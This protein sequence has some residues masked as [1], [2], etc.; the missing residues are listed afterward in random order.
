MQNRLENKS[1]HLLPLG[2]A[3]SNGDKS[4]KPFLKWAGGKRWLIPRIKY[5]LPKSFNRYFEPF[6][7]AGALFFHLRPTNGV[8][9][10][11]NKELINSYIQIR[12]NLPELL[13]QLKKLHYSKRI[14]NKLRFSELNSEIRRAVRF[15]Y[16]NKTCWNGLYRENKEGKFNVPFGRYENPKIYDEENLIEISRLLRN[17]DILCADFETAIQYAQKGDFIYLDPPYVTKAN[18]HFITYNASLF[19]WDDQLR[20]ANIFYGLHNLR[21]KVMLTNAC[22]NHIRKLYRGFSIAEIS[23][24][25]LISGESKGRGDVFELIIRNYST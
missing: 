19:S 7:G 16:L 14:Y 15:I 22:D 21:C 18:S 9:S 5:L 20:L 23:R 13:S 12:D 1:L 10:D 17:I 8:L 2:Q 11:L 6:L 24:K 3:E 25:S 4:P